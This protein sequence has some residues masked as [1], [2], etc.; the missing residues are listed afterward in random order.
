MSNTAT[1]NE[2]K[3]SNGATEAVKT[4]E[5]AAEKLEKR[6]SQEAG[7]LQRA[8]SKFADGVM[9]TA[10]ENPKATA[11]VALGVGVLLG[12]IA[13]RLIFPR[14]SMSE[15]FSRAV[16]DGAAATSRTLMLGV[17]SAGKMMH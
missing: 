17:K 3:K 10:R 1:H 9:T 12:A 16:R 4:V 8:T 6:V 13:H 11:G 2:T 15:L 5:L 7:R 14:R